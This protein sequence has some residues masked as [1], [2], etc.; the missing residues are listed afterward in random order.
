MKREADSHTVE[1]ET[2]MQ[3]KVVV[4]GGVAAGLKAACKTVRLCAEADVTVVEK[5]EIL[6]YAGCGLPYFISGVVRKREELFSTPI[7]V[8]RDPG[9][10][11]AVK[12]VKVLNRTEALSIDRQGKKV[13]VKHI[14]TG[15]AQTLPYD[16]LVVATGAQAFV[17]PIPGADLENVFTVKSVEDADRIR[18]L[19]DGGSVRKAVIVGG[20][21]IGVEM[22]ESLADCALDVSLVEMLPRIL[23]M[24]DPEMA[25]LVEK[26][27]D[28]HGIGVHTGV[29]VTAFEGD[30]SVEAV[31][32]G[33]LRLDADLVILAVGVRPAVDLAVE[34]GL[35][36]GPFRGIRVDDRMCTSDPDI[37]AAGDCVEVKNILTGQPSFIPLGSTA[38]KQGRV[39]AINLCGGDETFPGV[40]G[41]TV[42]KV[43]DL[44]VA[45]SG[46]SE[47]EARAA[48]FETI[49]C[50]VP[51]EDRAH[52]YPGAAGVILKLVADRES[53]RLLGAQAVG[54]GDVSK[55]IDAC[56]G[57]LTGSLTVDQVSKL[58]LC[59]APPYANA[60]DVLIT[61]A[62]VLKNKMES[63]FRGIGSAAV[64][65]MLD[66]GDDFVF[67][68]VRSPDEVSDAAIDGAV[69]IPL[70][71]LRTAHEQVPRHKPIIAFC[72]VSLRGYEASLILAAAGHDDVQVMEGGVAAWPF[73][74]TKS[75]EKTPGRLAQ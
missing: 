37:Y 34:A 1:T 60:L 63:R 55:R 16:K 5:G 40:L 10:F 18:A 49:T 12:K 42:V 8:A 23:P 66:R 21:L 4:I 61:A 19:V 22:A 72:A 28:M 70:G 62:N 36:I 54:T 41:S 9:F 58:D 33:D 38:N 32:C 25:L 15:E 59:Y 29:S 52:Y 51:G 6:S 68:D 30:R 39:A 48:G 50:C 45:R 56:V 13:L 74:V 27:L 75:K 43:C 24:L 2:I 44:A 3:L 57:A 17:P 73:A 20:G 14:E 69:N 46:L 35:E 47:S 67:L 31:V 65:E 64:K 11:K 26:H 7:G 71:T 53:G